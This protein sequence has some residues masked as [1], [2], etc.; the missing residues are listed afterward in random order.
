MID[1][2]GLGP[3]DLAATPEASR[4]LLL[5]PTRTVL[6]R[7]LQHPA[8]E[9]LAALRDVVSCDDLYERAE[10]FDDVYEAIADRVLATEDAVY[11]VPGSPTV[12]ELA[13]AK[14]R[15]RAETRIHPAESF[16]DAMF[17]RFGVD[18]LADGFQLLNGHELPAVLVFDV[19]TVI[20]HL[21]RAEI[22]ADVLARLD[23]ALPEEHEVTLVSGLGSS[24]E[25]TVHGHPTDLDPT[26]AGLRTSLFVPVARSGLV[27]VVDTMARLRLECPWDRQQTHETL[28][29]YLFE[30]TAE[31]ADAIAAHAVAGPQDMGVEAELEEELG[32][33]LLQ[34]LFHAAIAAE[35]RAFDI[36]DVAEVLRRKLVR[37]HPHVFGDVDADDADA[38]RANWEQIKASE[39][40]VTGDRSLM[41]GVPA[42][43][44]SLARAQEIQ[45]QA[46]KVGFDW[47]AAAEVFDDVAE[48]V[49]EARQAYAGGDV[50]AAGE[51]MGDVLFAAVNVARHLGVD[52]DLALRAAVHRFED[53]FRMMERE[54]P[55]AGLTLAEL[56]ARWER[57]KE[58]T[59]GRVRRRRGK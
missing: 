27:G 57:A 10:R 51:E 30:E 16:L 20:G 12:G 47:P 38:V 26:V 24:A 46:A 32:D 8:A 54:G 52:P 39:K 41:D 45:R 18:P 6:V 43:L 58:Q 56:D 29:R 19:P 21:D 17:H 35:A 59:Q 49:D 37:R 55:L 9:Q 11:A 5:D 23:R 28:V 33:V 15:A 34:V 7:T 4:R 53:R 42:S 3:G 48:E 36:T 50:E 31:L 1:I 40:Q 13:V 14:I 22:L 44:S 25:V 2:V